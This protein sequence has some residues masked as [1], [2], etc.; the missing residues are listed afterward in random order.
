[1]LNISLKNLSYITTRFG[2]EIQLIIYG[3]DKHEIISIFESVH[4]IYF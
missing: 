4:I 1:M 2:K 3:P